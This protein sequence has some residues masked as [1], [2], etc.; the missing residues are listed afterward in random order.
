MDLSS[1]T[2]TLLALCACA[3]AQDLPGPAALRLDH[4]GRERSVLLADLPLPADAPVGARRPIL[5]VLHGGGGSGAQ[6][7]DM[8]RAGFERQVAPGGGLVAYP[9]G[10]GRQ[11]N[12]GRRDPPDA[13]AFAQDV[14]DVGFL[15]ALVA[16]LVA[17][18]SGDPTRVYATGHS[19]GALLCWRLAAQGGDF[20]SAI[21]PTCGLLAEGQEAWD[22][23]R[24]VPVLLLAG[25]ADPMIP[26]AGGPIGPRLGGPR[27]RV[28]SLEATVAHVVARNGLAAAPVGEACLPDAA[29]GDGT[30]LQ[31]R[32]FRAA[33]PA[34]GEPAAPSAPLDVLVG[35]GAG[36][37]WPGGDHGR[38]GWI[39]GAVSA[40]ADACALVWEFVREQRR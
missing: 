37:T 10:V 31:L 22:W 6:M 2:L 39:T 23:P 20:V 11:W 25:D 14:D 33:A 15:R 27:G 21:A 12:D 26:V 17:E 35:A 13:E 34:A 3:A 18:R 16:L 5:L 29:P 24:P 9:D 38:R 1:P 19:N 8:T 4:G 7:R 40:D 30:R 28:H 36:H 32:R